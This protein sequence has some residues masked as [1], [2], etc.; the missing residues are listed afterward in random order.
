MPTVDAA[1]A[2]MM[3]GRIRTE[4]C[5]MT[6]STRASAAHRIIEAEMNIFWVIFSERSARSPAA[7]PR[8]TPPRL[9]MDMTVPMVPASNPLC[10]R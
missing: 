6:S 1:K 10:E 4:P 3:T 7:G 9:T 5:G 2:T 8:N